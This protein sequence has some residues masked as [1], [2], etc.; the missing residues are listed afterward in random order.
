MILP[1]IVLVL[2]YIIAPRAVWLA[3]SPLADAQRLLFPA[4]L[5]L[6]ATA[7]VWLPHRTAGNS[8]RRN[9]P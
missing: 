1:L 6:L 7:I 9:R 2:A 4:L 3:L 5:A 8:Q